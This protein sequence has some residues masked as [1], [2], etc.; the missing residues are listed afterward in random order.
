M[1]FFLPQKRLK[2][3]MT[4]DESDTSDTEEGR[5]VSFSSSNNFALH[6]ENILKLLVVGPLTKLNSANGISCIV[7]RKNRR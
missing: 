4:E 7:S 6:N 5:K 2:E 3:M 1:L